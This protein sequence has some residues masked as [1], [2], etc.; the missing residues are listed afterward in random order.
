MTPALIGLSGKKRSGKDTFAAELVE[1]HGFTR[2]AFADPLRDVAYELAPYVTPNC[3]RLDDLVD[4][5]GWDV[6][7][8]MPEARRILQDLGQAVR[9]LDRDFWLN[10]AKRT[11]YDL[12][13]RG[14]SVVIT[15][16][17]Y[18]NE[19][20]WLSTA[21]WLVRIERPGLESADQHPSETDLDDYDYFGETVVNDGTVDDL[22]RAAATTVHVLKR[23]Q[24]LYDQQHG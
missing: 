18:Q 9:Q 10:A 17:R 8:E 3:Y 14:R 11:V 2:V 20:G 5:Y 21:G 19:A 16:V 24:D 12:I 1:N 13:A 4:A 23:A 15:D 7:K 22:R 6:A